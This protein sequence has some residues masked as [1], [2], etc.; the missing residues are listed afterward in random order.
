MLAP[1]PHFDTPV[2]Q[3]HIE[4]FQGWEFKEGDV[5]YSPPPLEPLF[6]PQ[7]WQEP[8]PISPCFPLVDLLDPRYPMPELEQVHQDFRNFYPLPQ[9]LPLPLKEPVD[10]MYIRCCLLEQEIFRSGFSTPL[11]SDLVRSPHDPYRAFVP[12]TVENLI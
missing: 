4:F 1:A 3:R 5:R 7:V 10:W 2:D 9:P 11:T 12:N 8:L 6:P